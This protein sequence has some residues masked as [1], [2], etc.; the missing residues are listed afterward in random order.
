MIKIVMYVFTDNDNEDDVE[1]PADHVI[2][3][4]FDY[5]LIGL[6]RRKRKR[7]IN[8]DSTFTVLPCD[9]SSK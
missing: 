8:D 4:D 9:K 7:V 6:R 5:A 1:F 2:L 3:D